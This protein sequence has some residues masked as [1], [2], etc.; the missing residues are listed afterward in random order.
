MKCELCDV[1]IDQRPVLGRPNS[2]SCCPEH[3]KL[4]GD[5]HTLESA[6]KTYQKKKKQSDLADRFIY[7]K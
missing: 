7:G 3:A 6:R 2:K 1:E 5:A 4:L